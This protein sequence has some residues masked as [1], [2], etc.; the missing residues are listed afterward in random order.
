M[1]S[2]VYN[3][4]KGRLF[5]DPA[6]AINLSTD[7]FRVV[8]LTSAYNSVVASA[9]D[10]E[11]MY[12]DLSAFEVAG[13]NY[14]ASGSPLIGSAPYTVDGSNQ[15]R[16]SADNVTW[17]NATI[18]ARY[19]TIYCQSKSNALVCTIDFGSDKSS[20]NGDFTI[21]WSANGILNLSDA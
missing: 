6:A 7:A 9:I 8:L 16:W 19:A 3:S 20:S 12:N 1:S 18:T 21:Q 2:L 14:V 11:S 10:D 4:F 17:S 5:A 15:A 13:V